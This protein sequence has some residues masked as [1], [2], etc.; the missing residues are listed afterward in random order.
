MP[1]K[2]PGLVDD[3]EV[4]DAALEEAL[5]D[6]HAAE[7]AADDEDR[8]LLDDRLPGEAGLDPRVVVER[9]VLVRQLRVLR[10]PVVA[11]PLLTLEPVTLLRLFDA[12][13][14]SHEGPIPF[15]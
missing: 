10:L 3:A 8:G 12:V 2:S 1:P 7:A 14:F 4:G 5:G 15:L 6:E 13:V 11:K 9:L